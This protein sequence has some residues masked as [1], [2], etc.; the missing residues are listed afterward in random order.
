MELTASGKAKAIERTADKTA[1]IYNNPRPHPRQLSPVAIA[2]SR[3][4][5]IKGD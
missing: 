4:I 3:S 1:R 5:V 2:H